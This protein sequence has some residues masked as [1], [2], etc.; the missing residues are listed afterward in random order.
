M[1]LGD[2]IA[3]FEDDDFAAE[4]L[5]ALDDLAL[6][7]RVVSLADE[8]CIAMGEVAQQAVNAFVQKAGDGEWLTLIGLMSRADNPG[9]VF[10]RRVLW[11]ALEERQPIQR[12]H[13]SS[14]QSRATWSGADP[15]KSP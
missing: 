9:Q 3:R 15:P 1:L 8:K 6:M 14:N 2:V 4:T 11:S 5:V 7:A 12:P 13:N 10:L